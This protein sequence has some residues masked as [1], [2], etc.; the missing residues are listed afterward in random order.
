MTRDHKGTA[1]PLAT[2]VAFPEVA[3]RHAISIID[4]TSSSTDIAA[5]VHAWATKSG[6]RQPGRPSNL[7]LRSF[8]I[9]WLAHEIAQESTQLP[10]M[11][12]TLAT[13]VDQE[14]R[15][16]IGLPEQR[17]GADLLYHRLHHTEQLLLSVVDPQP[18][19]GTAE[20]AARQADHVDDLMSAL[21]ANAALSSPKF[22]QSFQGDAALQS[23]F[24]PVS[25]ATAKPEQ[26]RMREAGPYS[27]SDGA[28]VHRG[29]RLEKLP[30]QF[31]FETALLTATLGDTIEDGCLILGLG[32]H[33]PGHIK[34][35]AS[36]LLTHYANLGLPTRTLIV[37]RQYGCLPANHFYEIA[38]QQQW[39]LVREYSPDELGIQHA[40]TSGLT[41][42]NWQLR[43]DFRSEMNDFIL[44]EGT[45]YLHFM[46][47]RLITAV[48]DHLL[49]PDNPN[50]ID[51][52][53][54]TERLVRRRKY[55]L[56]P[57]G[58]ADR[59]GHRRYRLPNPAEYLAV[60][61]ATG[62][63]L[64][65]PKAKTVTIPDSEGIRWRQPFAYRSP[66]W[67][68]AHR[69]LTHRRR[70][71]KT[72]DSGLLVGGRKA[73]NGGYASTAIAFAMAAAAHNVHTIERSPHSAL[74][75]EVQR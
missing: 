62:E 55:Q 37:E 15:T 14:L 68:T 72:F 51:E 53:Q 16:M 73:R 9:V 52:D 67:H 54:L 18:P 25:D 47:A 70:W 6:A 2:P 74:R 36:T 22:R 23:G 33:R 39:Q 27:R 19:A 3:F 46:P 34:D 29:H 69:L 65:K 4:G 17:A 7:S 71:Q 28:A 43:R 75:K 40:Y 20:K 49:D 10:H 45:W 56:R 35:T 41:P 50:W 5:M 48:R 63:I 1:A 11:A 31:G 44:V 38:H 13:R 59:H 57:T 26:D 42:T 66:Q 32:L 64:D 21:V 30:V 24:I 12:H 8:L 60:D 58:S 61:P